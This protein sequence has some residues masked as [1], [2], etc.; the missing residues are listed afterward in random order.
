M[1]FYI[2]IYIYIYG[3]MGLNQI[4]WKNYQSKPNLTQGSNKSLTQPNSPTHKN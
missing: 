1:N 3:G 4:S 2:Y